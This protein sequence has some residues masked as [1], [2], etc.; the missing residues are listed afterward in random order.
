LEVEGA[1]GFVE[2]PAAAK[3][4]VYGQPVPLRAVQHAAKQVANPTGV[5]RAYVSQLLA[6]IPQQLLDAAHEPYGARALIFA[7]LLDRDADVRAVQLKEL[8]KAT[9]PH[10]FELTLRL[11]TAVNQLDVRGVLP[12]VDMTLPALRA[13][14]PAQYNEFTHSFVQLVEADHRLNL[15]EW[16]LHHVLLRHLRPQFEPVRTPQIAYYGL[17]RLADHCSVLLSALARVSQHD[18]DAAF[19]AGARQLP[20]VSLRLIPADDCSLNALDEALRELAQVAPKHRAR[21]VNA[22]AA[23]ICA[24][25]AVNVAEAEL[26]RAVCDMLDCP[27]PPIVAG[28]DVSPSLLAERETSGVS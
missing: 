13:L 25:A 10:V 14:S 22:C 23:C 5:H 4:D 19:E 24:D 20:E 12:L 15:F 1:E 3:P 7:L 27:M 28:Q 9:E 6:A 2:P 17:Q 8:E 26:L 11:A 18:D 16:T 21:L